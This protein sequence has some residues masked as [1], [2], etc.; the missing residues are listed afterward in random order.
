MPRVVLDVNVLV[1]SLITPAGNAARIVDAWRRKELALITSPAIIAKVVEV[2]RRPHLFDA[3]PYDEGDIA[4]LRE[5]LEDEAHETPGELN[6]RVIEQDP[7]DD[8]ILIAA[9][10]GIADCIVSGDA[11]LKNLGQYQGIPILSPAEFADQYRI[12]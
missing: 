2:L 12:P 1:A 8:T 10:E 7:E 3:Y 9:V 5:L 11:H 4:S 6:L